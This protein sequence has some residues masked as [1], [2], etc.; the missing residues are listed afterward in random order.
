[1]ARDSYSFLHFPMVA[2]I[3]L[4]ALGMK[5]TLGHVE[6]PLKL[7][8]AA[9]L[10]GGAAVYLLAHVAFRYRHIHSVNTRRLALAVM[11]VAFV[12]VAVQIPALATIA[13]LAV[14]LALLIAIETRSYGEA[15]ERVR[16]ELRHEVQ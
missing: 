10:L 9:A 15:R 12:P 5:K 4:V 6:D 3:V 2:G 16:R 8:P 14:A 13:V 7:V 11:L 1:M